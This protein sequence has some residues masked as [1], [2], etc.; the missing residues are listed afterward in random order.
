MKITL[1]TDNREEWLAHRQMGIGSSEVATILGLNPWETPYQLWRRKKGIDEGK[2]ESFA[3]KA[4]HYLEDA[5]SRF[6]MDETGHQVIKS[7][8]GDWV[9][10]D[11]AAPHRRVSPDRTFWLNGK[12]HNA[13][14]KGILECK[15][16]QLKVSEEDIPKHWFCQLQYQMG[17][18]GVSH[19]A[20]AWLV[21]GR[22][23]GHREFEFNP[24]LFTW[25]CEEVDKFWT[26]NILDNREPDLVNT[27]D[28]LAKFNQ[29]TEGKELEATDEL[30]STVTN[31][32]I[33]KDQ[34]KELEK[35][36]AEAEERIKLAMLDAEALTYMGTTI[37]T[38]RTSKPS[39]KLDT[40]TLAEDIPAEVLERHMTEVSGTR[41]FVLK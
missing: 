18:M 4:G 41:R 12:A 24:A 26:V 27:A 37:A 40:K 25:I 35:Q 31:L 13:Q 19:G 36:I 17:V 1:R 22:E 39:R 38:W 16:T 32:R 3:M 20:L 9:V 21:S 15:T 6:W 23:F 7:S 5:V 8:A 10:F 30:C 33:F 34:K 11:D 2:Q 29:H 14:N 28:V